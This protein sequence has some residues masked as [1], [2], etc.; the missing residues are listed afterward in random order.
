MNL[1]ARKE[2]WQTQHQVD[3]NASIIFITHLQYV[4]LF[5]TMYQFLIVYQCSMCHWM[6][7]AS[8]KY[9]HQISF[10]DISFVVKNFFVH[11]LLASNIKSYSQN[12][13]SILPKQWLMR[14]LIQ[15]HFDSW[16]QI[17]KSELNI[18]I[19]QLQHPFE[20][21]MLIGLMNNTSHDSWSRGGVLK[22]RC[23]FEL[24]RPLHCMVFVEFTDGRKISWLR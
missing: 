9:C 22:W 17:S 24:F 8:K 13:W 11:V 16:L 6:I 20:Y 1:R 10:W 15:S 18:V 2:S 14:S 7:F 12:T 4:K 5:D 21:R 23:H 3:I 19:I